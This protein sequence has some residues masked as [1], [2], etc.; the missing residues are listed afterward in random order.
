MYNTEDGKK[1]FAV[2]E[3]GD[4]NDFPYMNGFEDGIYNILVTTFSPDSGKL[5]KL[6][7]HPEN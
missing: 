1:A 6:L 5:S 7:N 3:I 4:Y 2:L